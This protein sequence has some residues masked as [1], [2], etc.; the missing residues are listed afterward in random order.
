[1]IGLYYDR[2]GMSEAEVSRL[3]KV[4]EP[5]PQPARMLLQVHDALLFEYPKAM[6]DRVLGTVKRVMEQPW[7]ELQGFHIPAAVAIGP[8]WGEVK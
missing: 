3:V 8:S 2:I 5:L 1:M 6:R 4:F 7:P